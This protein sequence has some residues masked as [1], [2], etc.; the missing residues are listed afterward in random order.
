M[1]D[2]EAFPDEN[3]DSDVDDNDKDQNNYHLRKPQA[4][5][6][7]VND[8]AHK[9]TFFSIFFLFFYNFLIKDF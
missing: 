8:E 4:H 5:V 9:E 7:I 2:P 6:W 3:L 1:L